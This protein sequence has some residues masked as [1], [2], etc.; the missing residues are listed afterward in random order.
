MHNSQETVFK[1]PRI[2]LTT[3]RVL[4]PLIFLVCFNAPTWAEPTVRTVY[5]DSKSL[6]V[7]FKLPDLRFS[8][9]NSGGQSYSQVS[10][11]GAQHTLEVGYPKLPT[12][13]QL[14]GIPVREVPQAT[15]INSRLEIHPTKKVLPVQSDIVRESE[16]SLGLHSMR[17][18]M[19]LDF[20]SPK[21][22]LSNT[23]GGGHSSRLHSRSACS[24][25]QD[26]ANSI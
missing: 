21:P 2:Q 6:I 7:E 9:E 20:L 4:Y 16:N 11:N 15:I 12:Y 1:S 25:T 13:S 24:A 18:E 17:N 19:N 8:E 26:S 5:I 14:I 3:F 23:F 10:F 22:F